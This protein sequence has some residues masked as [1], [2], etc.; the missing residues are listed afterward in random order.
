MDTFRVRL[1]VPLPDGW[2]AK[3]SITLVSSD[4]QANVIASSE[5]LDPEFDTRR[6]AV[7]QGDILSADFNEYTEHSFESAVV[8]GQPG[9]VRRYSWT[10]PDGGLP[11]T[12]VQ[13]YFATNGRGYTVTATTPSP[14]FEA[15]ESEFRSVLEG[16]ALAP[17]TGG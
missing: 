7:V 12:Q 4:G 5:P 14:T 15:F 16:M 13:A 10:P 11:V 1:I 2:F 17:P 6:Y 9:Y 3:E 8:F